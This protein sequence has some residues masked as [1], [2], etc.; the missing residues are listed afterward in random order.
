MK[1]LERM[2]RS[3]KLKN[4]SVF[5]RSDFEKFGD[6]SNV[7]RCLKTLVQDGT[8][9]RLY[10]GS[11]ALRE[12]FERGALLQKLAINPPTARDRAQK[13]PRQ[14]QRAR[15][16]ESMK[17]QIASAPVGTFHVADDFAVPYGKRLARQSLEMLVSDEVLFRVCDGMYCSYVVDSLGIAP[18]TLK[19]F[20]D[21]YVRKTG[22]TVVEDGSCAANAFHFTTQ[23]PCQLHFLTSG[24]STT[25]LRDWE[26]VSLLHADEWLLFEPH[27]IC[28]DIVRAINYML[29]WQSEIDMN[30]IKNSLAREEIAHLYELR[31]K[32]PQHIRSI[33]EEAYNG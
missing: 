13:L 30:C 29:K 27:S 20:V 11:Y 15:L 33:L 23:F 1:A 5:T 7:T 12:R 22:E 32:F 8:L 28:G 10:H 14:E 17:S 4:K 3:L 18:P 21:G 26:E 2:K 6:K 9:M 19:E 24:V 25:L 31:L 16:I